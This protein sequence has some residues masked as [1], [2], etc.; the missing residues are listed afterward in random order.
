MPARTYPFKREAVHMRG[1]ACSSATRLSPFPSGGPAAY[2]RLPLML[3]WSPVHDHRN[4]PH[5][6]GA[7]S[8]GR[9]NPGGLRGEPPGARSPGVRTRRQPARTRKDSACSLRA[10]AHHSALRETSAD[11]HRADNQHG[12]YGPARYAHTAHHEHEDADRVWN[13]SS[14]NSSLWITHDCFS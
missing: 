11:A 4:D 10:H 8:P 13:D 7:I 3:V 9:D 5:A 14:G 1:G 2:E 6:D 12:H